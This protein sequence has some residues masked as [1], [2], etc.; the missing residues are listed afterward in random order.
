MSTTIDS[1]VVEMRFENGQFEQGVSQSMSSIEKLKQSLNFD[2]AS[3]AAA[4]GINVVVQGF[5][6]LN[7]ALANIVSSLANNAWTKIASVIKGL[8]V[9]NI[10]EGWSKYSTLMDGV[11][12]IMSATRDQWDDQNAQME[13]MT[14][15]MEKLN[16]YTDETSWNMV[17]MTS[18]IGKFISAGVDIET[19]TTA[20]MGIGSWAGQSG[21]KV[22]QMSRA[23]YN[24]SQAMGMGTVKVQDWMSIENANMA[25]KEF[26]ETVIATALE[27][28]ELEY[29]ADGNIV[30]FDKFGKEVEVTAE[31]FRST[32][33]AGWFT[34]DVLTSTLKKY[35]DFAEGLHKT[36]DETGLTAAELLGHIEDYKKAME[37]GEDM[38]TWV[39]ELANEEHVSNVQAL[40]EG[41]EYLSNDYNALGLAAFKAS[42]ETRTFKDLQLAMKDAVSSAW[43]GIFQVVVGNYLESKELWSAWAEELY[44][45]FV[46]PL[47]NVKRILDKAFNYFDSGN[48]FLQAMWNAW[49]NIKGIL[50]A[51]QDA[52]A[53][54]F[55]ENVAS[56]ILYF[57]M[58][59]L[60]ITEKFKLLDLPYYSDFENIKDGLSALLNVVKNFWKNIQTIAG[61]IGDAWDRIFPKSK[62][63][64]VT[65]TQMFK[66][67]A[68]WL[69]KVSEKFV[70]SYES[71]EKLERTFAGVFAVIDILK[72]L[73]FALIE[74]F[75]DVE[76]GESGLITNTLSVTATIGDWLVMLRDW[77]KENDIFRNAVQG[78][79]NFI[80]SIPG[81]LDQVCQELFGLGLDEVWENIKSAAQSAWETI[82]NFFK[83]L[84]TYAEEASQA[85]FGMSLAEV[86]DKI[87][88]A[89]Q[90]AWDKLKEVFAW[91]KEKFSK[92]NTEGTAEYGEGFTESLEQSGEGVKSFTEKL[93]EAF[94]K[95]KEIWDKVKPYLDEIANGFKEAFDEDSFNGEGLGKGLIGGGIFVVLLAVAK[96][97]LTCVDAFEKLTKN[98]DKIVNSISGMF[99]NIGNA[100]TTVSKSLAKRISADTIKTIA[101]AILELAAAIFVLSLINQDKMVVSA[102]VISGLMAVLAVIMDSFDKMT[103]DKKKFSQ[104]KVV[105]GEMMILI[106]EIT[107]AIVILANQNLT[108]CVAAAIIIGALMLEIELVIERMA[109]LDK[110]DSKQ[111]VRVGALAAMMGKVMIEIAAA[112]SIIADMPIAG[113]LA[114]GLSL[115]ALLVVMT[116]CMETLAGAEG[117]IV[118]AAASSMLMGIAMMELSIALAILGNMDP[119]SLVAGSLALSLVLAVLVLAL[120]TLAQAEGNIVKGAAAMVLASA[121]LILIAGALAIVSAVV[122]SGN[123]I[124]SL[125]ALAA[126]LAIILI[127][128]IPAEKL[129]VGLLALGAAVALIGAGAMMA[130]AGLVLFAEAV[131]R[132]VAAGPGAV[133]ILV[134]GL[135]SFFTMIPTL[136]TKVGQAFVN[137]IKVFIDSK[138][139]I[140]E[141]INTMIDIMYEAAMNG[142]PKLLTVVETFLVGV[143]DVL[144]NIT[145]KIFEFLTTFFNNLWPFL[146]EQS[147]QLCE[148]LVKL[149]MDALDALVAITFK[150]TESALAILMD[151]LEKLAENIAPITA[152]LVE[153][154]IGTITG[155]FDGLTAALPQ[156]M[157][158]VWNFVITMIESFAD[159]LDDHAK[160]L[161]DA[162]DHLC[163]SVWEAIKT[164]F[165]IHSPS[166]KFSEL[167]HNMI[168]GMI[169]GLGEMIEKAKEKI[170]ELADKVLTA[171]CNFFGVDKPTSVS[172]LGKMGHDIIQNMID[173]ISNMI[174]KAKEKITELA[175]KVLT[176][177]CDFFGIKK[178]EDANEFMN[179]GKTIIQK[180][181]AGIYGMIEKAK[182]MVTDFA[183]K[184][185]DAVCKF[186]G[187]ETPGSVGELYSIAKDLIN[188]F[189]EGI[190]DKVNDAIY[191]VG[192]FCQ[193]VVDKCKN[194]FK[195]ASPSKVFMEIGAFLDEGL[196]IGIEKNAGGVTDATENMG[197]MAIDSL[198]GA[199]SSITDIIDG[200]INYDPTIRPVLDVSG[201]ADGVSRIDG[202]LSSDRTMDLAASSSMDINSKIAAQHDSVSALDSLR[203]SL[204]GLSNGG[205]TTTQ[206][207]TFNISGSNPKEIADEINKIL[208]EQMVREDSVW[209]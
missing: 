63:D 75:A 202:M 193:D 71:A 14:K 85:L 147:P 156:L 93:S 69:E 132:L 73:L 151:V 134:D 103:L 104:I 36:V 15:Q 142:L 192:E 44:E 135:A 31:T 51:V 164:F 86:W 186:F 90:S 95:L 74:P 162:I 117:N 167:A 72:E 145:P 126:A 172:E 157:E 128:A 68:E 6:M 42:Q 19:A 89:A 106:A 123:I 138:N 77:I 163:V 54:I 203:A 102:A 80:K 16:W 64:T 182:N 48:Y 189:I 50:I 23:M 33:A 18:N 170:T 17:D 99:T 4:N 84:P 198:S 29:N 101:T 92:K 120:M 160:E 97:I 139:T 209:A 152:K 53:S 206:N 40:S 65:I 178:P 22:D 52:F 58:D 205:N 130:G 119:L 11:Q 129:S 12:V 115:A 137:L 200:M 88:E 180:F 169:N 34:G 37:N 184:V 94:D 30:A 38:T 83:N 96:V 39:Q 81:K 62:N 207:N 100:F 107:A 199:I 165:G 173:G 194:V 196:A 55:P 112:L 21:A 125:V 79:V 76:E 131:E 158:S 140:L 133:D 159:G 195:V 149:T 150:I 47:N 45:V 9:D 60:K 175:D 122:S 197:N 183:K 32:L 91:I 25:T 191:A 27:M 136:I 148:T 61:A 10:A 5:D 181:N 190:Y 70:L 35:G 41:L 43:M 141:G 56:K 174:G 82:V 110:Y 153:I 116:L 8:T 161:K 49:Y 59:L 20:M 57:S 13:Y 26:K 46:D 98:K 113:I 105:L 176:A 146:I 177:I 111:M 121:S 24:L 118:K 7:Y 171:I 3:A 127:A 66:S 144:I 179:L 28:G 188:G 166:T 1:N 154:L 108:G 204:S 168:Q 2:T 87:K 208:Q 201:I 143:L 155:T 109:G 124:E 187:V 67:L 114:G 185:L 78:V